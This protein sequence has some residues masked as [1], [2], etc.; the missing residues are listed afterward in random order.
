MLQANLGVSPSMTRTKIEYRP[1]KAQRFYSCDPSGFSVGVVRLS[2]RGRQQFPPPLRGRIK[3]GGSSGCTSV[4]PSQPSPTRGE[5]APYGEFC[6]LLDTHGIV[7]RT[8][9]F[10][11]YS[12]YSVSRAAMHGNSVDGF[13]GLLRKRGNRVGG[14][15]TRAVLPHHR[16]CGSAYGGS[17]NT[18]ESCLPLQDGDQ[19]QVSEVRGGEGIVQVRSP[20]V[21]PRPAPVPR[22]P[23]RSFGQ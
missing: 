18:L 11:L 4:P 3:V 23:A 12:A 1:Q 13:R 6:A 21:P 22:R 19:P 10:L 20:R 2:A 8:F 15:V 9:L 14:A 16:T 5:G 17:L 7:G